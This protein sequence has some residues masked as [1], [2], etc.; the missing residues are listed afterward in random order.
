MNNVTPAEEKILIR[1]KHFNWRSYN[2]KSERYV[3]NQKSGGFSLSV[4]I[5]KHLFRD[6]KK[7]FWEFFRL[8]W[9]KFNHLVI[10][11]Y[12]DII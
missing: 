10:K 1:K 5:E 9:E 6:D 7:K 8:G 12:N 4:L 3:F 11:Y 2:K